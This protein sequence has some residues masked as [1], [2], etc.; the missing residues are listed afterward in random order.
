MDV[1]TRRISR[2]RA[3]LRFPVGRQADALTQESRRDPDQAAMKQRASAVP[4]EAD[5]DDIKSRYDEVLT[6]DSRL[7]GRNRAS[8]APG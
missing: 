5:R 8:I 3:V 7:A 1:R 6:T 4:E 2:P